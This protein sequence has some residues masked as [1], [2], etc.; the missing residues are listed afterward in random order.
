MYA[1]LSAVYTIYYSTYAFTANVHGLKLTK[2][3]SSVTAAQSQTKDPH[4][5]LIIRDV[6]EF[7][8][9]SDFE[10]TAASKQ[11]QAFG[12]KFIQII[13]TKWWIWDW[14][15]TGTNL[16]YECLYMNGESGCMNENMIVTMTMTMAI[17]WNASSKYMNK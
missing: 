12:W 16:I 8:S 14:T 10:I 2:I 1:Q 7:H 17:N 4:Q 3:W 15:V 5:A 6:F 11:I 13:L 9:N